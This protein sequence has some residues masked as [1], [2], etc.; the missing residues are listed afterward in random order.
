[1]VA[2]YEVK[3]SHSRLNNGH[4]VD[5]PAVGYPIAVT[6][7]EGERTAST[8]FSVNIARQQQQESFYDICLNDQKAGLVATCGANSFACNRMELDGR[9]TI[10]WSE[11]HLLHPDVTA[12]SKSFF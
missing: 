7:C 8:N 6:V 9:Y 5:L 12:Y 2:H 1:M 10:D 11:R 4:Q 3:P